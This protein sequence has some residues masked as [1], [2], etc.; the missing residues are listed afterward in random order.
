MHVVVG[1]EKE[2]GVMFG[3]RRECE[4]QARPSLGPFSLVRTRQ[5]HMVVQLALVGEGEPNT[6]GHLSDK[7]CT[8]HKGE[9]VIE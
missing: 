4:C 6:L 2:S 9:A 3:G 1:R 7:H 5:A 8:I